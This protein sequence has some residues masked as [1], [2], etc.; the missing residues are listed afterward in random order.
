MF[1]KKCNHLG[2]LVPL[3]PVFMEIQ[4]FFLLGIFLWKP[5]KIGTRGS[6]VPEGPTKRG[7]GLKLKLIS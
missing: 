1:F 3:V 2:A 5:S 4:I 6:R 7:L